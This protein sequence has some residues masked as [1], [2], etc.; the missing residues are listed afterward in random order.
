M[1]VT[2]KQGTGYDAPWVVFYGDSASEVLANMR[3]FASKGGFDAVR[4]AAGEFQGRS[5]SAVEVIQE[6][7]PGAVVVDGPGYEPGPSQGDYG[8]PSG[9][10]QQQGYQQQGNLNPQCTTCGG[11]TEFKSGVGAKG[12]WSAYFCLATSRAPKEQKHKPIW[13]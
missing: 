12:P 11:A 4:G 8:P 5:P 13:S 9:G 10:Y 7:F 1:S 6:A 3:D 2:L